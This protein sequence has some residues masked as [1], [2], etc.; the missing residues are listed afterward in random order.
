MNRWGQVVFHSEDIA[1]G[2]DGTINGANAPVGSYVYKMTFVDDINQTVE[3]SGT[4]ML[5][6]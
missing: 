1:T 3:K 2:W 5:L 6:R 4:F